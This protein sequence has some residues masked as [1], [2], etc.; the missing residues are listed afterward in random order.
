[1]SRAATLWLIVFLSCVSLHMG[2]GMQLPAVGYGGA[3]LS[4]ILGA[5]PLRLKRPT[6]GLVFI[7]VAAGGLLGYN[8]L[9]DFCEPGTWV[10]YGRTPAGI[11]IALLVYLNWLLAVRGRGSASS[12][13][14]RETQTI[15]TVGTA[16][17]VVIPTSQQEVVQLSGILQVPL[18][19]VAGVI[20]AV[21]VFVLPR[22]P[23]RVPAR[24]MILIFVFVL[25]PLMCSAIRA[26][27]RPLISFLDG[28]VPEYDYYARTGFSPLL[29]MT[30][31]VFLRPSSRP[32][33]RIMCDRLPTRYMAGNRLVLLD[34][35]SMTW[36]PFDRKRGPSEIP[37]EALGDGAFLYDFENHHHP[38][39]QHG[40]K[41]MSVES[42][43]YEEV[44]FVPFGADS[45][46]GR[47]TELVRD[48]RG[49][50]KADF[51]RR[52]E[53]NW[54]V[55]FGGHTTPENER[56]VNCLLPDFWDAPLDRKSRSFKGPGRKETVNN[57]TASFQQRRYS[58]HT[59]YDKDAPFHDFFLNEKPG[60]CYWF[61]SAA[62]LALRANDIPARLV[63][64]FVVNENI[65]DGIWLVRERD[66]HSWVEWQDERGYWHRADPT[67]ASIVSYY[68]GYRSFFLSRW[69][70]FALAKWN[71][72]LDFVLKTSLGENVFIAAGLLIL[73][74]LFKREYARI[75]AERDSDVLSAAQWKKLWKQ[76][77]RV[78][79]LPSHP[80]WTAKTYKEHLPADWSPMKRRIAALFLDR[81][82]QARFGA[83]GASTAEL[84]QLLKKIKSI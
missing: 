25:A 60:Y 61:A 59:D 65:G 55:H 75:S 47:F 40:A 16:L 18:L 45:V 36:L 9:D 19:Q 33:M 15:V 57:V 44:L 64:G 1:M 4:V 78:S 46:S 39:L 74:W 62:V 83:A 82:A 50:L 30:P 10:Y 71:L 35:S 26:T 72:F 76:F 12:P 7:L 69:Y 29:K 81:Y 3:I 54:Q 32:V 42:F 31:S 79:G 27:Q 2:L 22:T 24:I 51:E 20:A 56:P 52:S 66:A 80:S 48:D 73:A 8:M 21:L 17:L 53:K 11:C 49:V 14:E 84:Q 63:C 41:E 68:G 43:Q 67:P 5:M 37:P 13:V 58:L 28:I 23:R 38:D 77:L 34:G 6:W 70:H